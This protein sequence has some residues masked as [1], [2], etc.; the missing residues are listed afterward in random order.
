MNKKD[1]KK[2]IWGVANRIKSAYSLSM[3]TGRGPQRKERKDGRSGSTG[4][5]QRSRKPTPPEKPQKQSGR[6]RSDRWREQ[7]PLSTYSDHESG[8]NRKRESRPRPPRPQVNR[9]SLPPRDALVKGKAPR[10]RGAFVSR[11]TEQNV[12]NPQ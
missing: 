2:C 12:N 3:E 9:E 6:G 10:K 5:L 11:E 4:Y 8:R 7:G 1:S